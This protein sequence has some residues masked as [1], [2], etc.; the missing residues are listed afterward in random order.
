[1]SALENL[2]AKLDGVKQCGASWMARCPAH[3]DSNPSLTI[4]E[5]ANGD[6]GV[7]VHCHAGCSPEAVVGAIGM[8]MADLF[9]ERR[10]RTELDPIE[11]RYRYHDEHGNVRYE[12]VRK[13]GKKFLQRRPDGQGGWIWNL[14]GVEPLLY[15]LP[16]LVHASPVEPV[17][18]CEGE[19]DVDAVRAAGGV[20][21][22]NSGGAGK[23]P[24]VAGLARQVLAGRDVI[25]V[26]DQ[27]EPGRKHARD[28][29][30]SLVGVAKSITIANPKAGKD[31]AEH[32]GAGHRLDDL[33]VVAT[34]DPTDFWP[35]LTK[36]LASQ[37]DEPEADDDQGDEHH[38]DD[39]PATLRS[40]LLTLDQ[41]A[42]L[43]PPRPL[44]EGLL[45]LDNLS[46][47]Y[48]P[49][50]GYKTFTVL[51]MALSV[52][53]GMPWHGRRT[54]QGLVIYVV[55]EGISGVHQ[56][57]D[58]WRRLHTGADPSDNMLVLPEA[59][60]LLSP[61]SVSEF[62]TLA[63]DLRAVFVVFD[64]LAR[65]MLGGDENSA[66]DA[67]LAI[68]AMDQV[69][70]ASGAHV[71][72][73]H[74]SGKEAGK[75]ARGSSAF[76]AAADT[77]LEVGASESIVTMRTTKQ[78]NRAEGHPVTLKAEP[79][80][81][82]LVL[83]PHRTNTAD[84][85]TPKARQALSVLD[86]IAG[87]IGASMTDWVK[88]AN[89]VGVGETTVKRTRIKALNDGWIENGPNSTERFARYIVTD[90]GGAIARGDE[91]TAGEQA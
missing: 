53:S 58:A 44:I 25:I 13:P 8:T 40:K 35:D 75:G 85:V 86:E 88:A 62:A 1:M 27:D 36:W 50:G 38:D 45:D 4:S 33:D 41:I 21:T 31:V 55:A 15:Q 32:L 5:R 24:K 19:K 56:R 3:D 47:I 48:G 28:V 34:S 52:A 72:A 84:E 2:L 64:T 37:P 46:M 59:V 91:E 54:T 20:A 87:Q 63:A 26:P 70:R 42:H 30:T 16:A 68:A 43:P 76:E 10:E 29:A 74:H 49:R 12:V 83:T 79:C 14:K 82:S 71:D 18:A 22:C 51:D 6:P 89:E 65:C 73:V 9:D 69:R 66:Q 11:Q 61:S 60:N 81:A 39:Q 23:W 80:G 67:G 17:Y 78:K 7:V 77:V 90:L 57:V